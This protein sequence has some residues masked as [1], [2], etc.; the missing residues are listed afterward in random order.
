MKVKLITYP[1]SS[2]RAR[3]RGE[4]VW[5]DREP[6][7]E[8]ASLYDDLALVFE[9]MVPLFERCMKVDLKG[10]VVQVIVEAR[11]YR[12]RSGEVYNDP[13]QRDSCELVKGVG[14]YF[15]GD[16]PADGLLGGDLEI[17]VENAGNE[18]QWLESEHV[19]CNPGTAVVINNSTAYRKMTRLYNPGP[20]AAET[21]IIIF[22]VLDTEVSAPSSAHDPA[23]NEQ[24]KVAAAIHD[25]ME[26]GYE[27][28]DTYG[29]PEA[30]FANFKEDEE[31]NTI[32]DDVREGRFPYPASVFK[33]IGDFC[34][35]A[36]EKAYFVRDRLREEIKDPIRLDRLEM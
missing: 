19:R 27:D 14:Y 35:G 29:G 2:S 4:S 23:T 36:G 15:V 8:G 3:Q 16:S 13:L 7:E 18:G 31:G 5:G 24:W 33:L 17:H 1:D 28:E 10:D 21:T 32:E 6:V 20:H 34:V 25:W 11:T 22:S 12:L 30:F 9:K 26:Y